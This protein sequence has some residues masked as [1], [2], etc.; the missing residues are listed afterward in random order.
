MKSTLLL[1]AAAAL[2]AV[3][4][5]SSVSEAAEVRVMVAVGMLD[6]GEEAKVV[7]V[8]DFNRRRGYYAEF[9]KLLAGSATMKDMV[10]SGWRIVHVENVRDEY[11]IVIFE[12]GTRA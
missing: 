8:P 3:I 5:L 12:R 2:A 10:K 11:H 7:S 4:A 1:A 9:Q 6:Y